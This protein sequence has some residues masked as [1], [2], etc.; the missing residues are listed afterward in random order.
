MLGH[1]SLLNNNLCPSE[2]IASIATVSWKKTFPQ[3]Q[4]NPNFSKIWAAGPGNLWQ[5]RLIYPAFLPIAFSVGT[6]HFQLSQVFGKPNHRDSPDAES[7]RCILWFALQRQPRILKV[8]FIVFQISGSPL[9]LF[10]HFYWIAR[11]SSNL[12]PHWG[13]GNSAAGYE[14]Q[15]KWVYLS[16]ARATW[17]ARTCT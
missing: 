4:Q 14:C 16:P 7:I 10:F 8:W 15:R 6:A 13:Q 3:S 1:I 2:R 17:P 12:W 9:K 5:F 11:N